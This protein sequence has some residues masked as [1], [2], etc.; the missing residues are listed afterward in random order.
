MEIA[1]VRRLRAALTTL[2]VGHRRSAIRCPVVEREID[3][4]DSRIVTV[5]W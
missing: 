1:T 4:G 5:V 2:H 3:N